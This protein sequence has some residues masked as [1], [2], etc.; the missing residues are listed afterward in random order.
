MALA[1]ADADPRPG[2][3]VITTSSGRRHNPSNLRSDVLA[4]AV[5]AANVELAKDG[6]AS[7]GP[8]TFHSMRRSYAS[9]RVASGDSSLYVAD[10][11]GHEDSRFTER[12]YRQATK[13]RDRLTGAH[14][15]ANDRALD[16]A[17]MGSKDAL[18]VPV[19]E[20]A[21]V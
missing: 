3:Y 10:Q 20:E 19:A 4:P 13:R 14:L 7:I 11:L 2:D 5:K 8:I 21:T 1:R 9:L 15:K 12:V 16:W 17:A 18:R 6:I